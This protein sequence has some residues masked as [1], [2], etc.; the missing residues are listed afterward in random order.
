MLQGFE[1]NIN[2]MLTSIVYAQNAS[3]DLVTGVTTIP[4]ITPINDIAYPFEV[5][6]H[7]T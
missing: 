1:F 7:K 2:A 3:V 6:F 4:A 5:V